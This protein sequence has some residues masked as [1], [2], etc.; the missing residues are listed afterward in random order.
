V[1]AAAVIVLA[2]LL[3]IVLRL[4]EIPGTSAIE[5][6]ATSAA[7]RVPAWLKLKQMIQNETWLRVDK[8]PL[9][10]WTLAYATAICVLVPRCSEL[11][12]DTRACR[13]QS[14]PDTPVSLV[15]I[16]FLRL[17]REDGDGLNACRAS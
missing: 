12:A 4:T 14:E 17:R 10:G 9:W 5:A 2:I 15:A 13:L 7:T 6:T 3:K 16:E 8:P 1:L 11:V